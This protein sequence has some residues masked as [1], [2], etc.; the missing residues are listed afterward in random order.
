MHAYPLFITERFDW[1][2][3]GCFERR[4]QS[5]EK[6]GYKTN[7]YS[8]EEPDVGHHKTCVQHNGK[9]VAYYNPQ[10]NAKHCT[11]QA[12]DDGLI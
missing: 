11:H 5:C 3:P 4:I 10:H 2:Q 12:D 8:S 6:A 1:I 9:C 7:E